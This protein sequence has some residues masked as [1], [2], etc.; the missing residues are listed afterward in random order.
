MQKDA[1]YADN[2]SLNACRFGGRYDC[3]SVAQV[4]VVLDDGRDVLP[5]YTGTA[6]SVERTSFAFH[7]GPLT[8][9]RVQ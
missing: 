7:N 5:T 6:S 9:I 3:G 1:L 8:G 4:L 2:D